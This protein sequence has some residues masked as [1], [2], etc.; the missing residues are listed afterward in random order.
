MRIVEPGTLWWSV[1]HWLTNELYG[2]SNRERRLH[3]W[4]CRTCNILM[5]SEKFY[6]MSYMETQIESKGYTYGYVEPG[7]F[8]WSVRHSLTNE[9]YRDSDKERRLHICIC[10]QPGTFWW[11]VRHSLT[12]KLYGNSDRERSLHMCATSNI[13]NVSMKR[14]SN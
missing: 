2:D 10:R 12:N 9:L 13:V 4:V 14:N 8:W 3:I 1:R 11:S 7:T 5:I 6:L